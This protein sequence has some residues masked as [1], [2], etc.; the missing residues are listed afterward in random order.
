MSEPNL[1]RPESVLIIKPSSLGDVITA[2]PVLAGIRRTFPQAHV[3]WLITPECAPILAGQKDLDEVILFDRRRYGFVGRSA[4]ATKDFTAFCR[5]LRRRRFDWVIDL[6]G[7]FRSGFFARVS[8]AGVRAGFADAR[9]FAAIFYTHPICVRAVHTVD[10]NL[11]L[12]RALGAEAGLEDLALNITPEAQAFAEALMIE[13]NLEKGRYLVIAPGTRWASKLYPPRH[14]RKV[15]DELSR[16]M[17]VVL[18]G[19]D[20]DAEL[21]AE[22]SGGNGKIFN[23]AG[24]TT[25][26]DVV[27]IIASSAAVLTCDSSANFIAPA[28]GAPFVTLVGPTRPD[29]TGP[30][31]SLGSVIV[32]DV[33]CQGCLKRRCR[34]VRGL[35]SRLI[36]NGAS[37]CMQLIKPEQVI[38]AAR[39]VFSRRRLT[40]S[41]A[42]PCGDKKQR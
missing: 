41:D 22:V 3:A 16:D 20:A 1:S 4:G 19:S 12:A 13:R 38:A 34:H 23:L 14:W 18:T 6:Q 28:V 5:N 42:E 11:A 24:Q 10:R 39:E 27:A 33:P 2:I 40:V 37:T 31:G 36:E 26:P 30:V 17:P 15:A 9:E 25:L 29:R 21:C 8:G 7:L 32:A 35:Q